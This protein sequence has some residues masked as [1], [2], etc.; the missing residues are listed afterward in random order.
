M[1]KGIWRELSLRGPATEH[2]AAGPSNWKYQLSHQR[3][4]YGLL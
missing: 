1:E 3:I 2:D 4:D